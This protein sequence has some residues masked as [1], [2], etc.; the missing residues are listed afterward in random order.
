MDS[1]KCSLAKHSEID[2]IYFCQECKVNFCKKCENYHSEIF[3]NHH[4]FKLD[5]NSNEI[6]TG[7]CKEENHFDKLVYF[8]KTHNQLCCAACISK[9]KG[10]G[11]GQHTD[12]DI[13]FIEEIKNEKK[14]A[15][16]DNIQKLENFANIL[17]E[18]INQLKITFDKM[19]DEKEELKLSI[20]K[21][22]TKIRNKINE[23]EDEL[24]KEIDEQIDSLFVDEKLIKESEKYPNKIKLSLEKGKIIDDEW[25]NDNKL[26]S[27]IN[28][29]I[30]IEND[31]QNIN[32]IFYNK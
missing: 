26:S 11:N 10:K 19:K 20:Q 21:I 18:T 4:L 8:C 29:C 25:E 23:R 28:D 22:F 30:N 2:A 17:E 5:K 14:K 1:K 15:L 32:N 7:F 31:I 16:K 3:E 12:C 24:L 9:I 13:V 27:I 6:F